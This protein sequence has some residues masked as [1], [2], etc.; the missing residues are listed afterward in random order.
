MTATFVD[1]TLAARLEAAC[2]Y[3]SLHYAQA[4]AAHTHNVSNAHTNVAGALVIYGGPSVP[5]NRAIGLGMFGPV[6]PADLDQIEAFY[7]QFQADSVIDLCPL[8]DASLPR[9]LAGRGYHLRNWMSMLYMPLPAPT[10]SYTPTLRVTRATA[11]QADL[12]LETSARGF[13]ETDEVAE[14]TRRILI[15]NF[16]AAHSQCYFAWQD[17]TPV[18]TAGMY[19]HAG[20]VELGGASTLFAYRQ[21]GA[22]SALIQQRLHDAHALGCD[23]AIVLT[24]PGSASQRNMQRRGFHLAYTRAIFTRP[25]AANP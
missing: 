17:A 12:W 21:R 2:A 23:L 9:L 22:Q 1:P 4:H 24:S 8:A 14:A 18:A 13:D 6:T 10:P 16:H 7:H 15:P 20:V 3:R 19:L 5:V 25:Y 11:D